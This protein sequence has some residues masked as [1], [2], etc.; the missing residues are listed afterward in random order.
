MSAR[1]HLLAALLALCSA[2]PVS[3]APSPYDPAR[4]AF[5]GAV[6]S[7]A[8]AASAALVGADR[9]VTPVA[10]GNP[11]AAPEAQVIVLSPLLQRISRQD[12]SAANRDFSQTT[13]FLDAASGQWA[14]RS[15]DWSLRLEASQPVLRRE[16]STFSVGL[17]DGGP[18]PAQVQVDA[19]SRELRAGLIVGRTIGDWRLGL[20]GEWT[21]RDDR[22]ATTE[23]SGSPDAGQRTLTFD[24]A[25][26][27]GALGAMWS[28][29]PAARWGTEV[30]ATLRHVGAIDAPFESESD[31]LSGRTT[32]AGEATRDA[33]WE[34]GLGMRL[35][36][37]ERGG[38]AWASLEARG[39]ERWSGLDLE[40]RA[41]SSWRVGYSYRDARTPWTLRLGFGQDVQP[42]APEPRATAVG[43]GL[44]WQD[45]DFGVDLGATHRSVR[46]GDAPTEGDIRLVASVTIGL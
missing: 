1:R 28:R 20:A 41:A 16:T 12:L 24:G 5:P 3:A 36:V 33:T 4:F 27:G 23:V 18:P 37:D 14:V 45:G 38:H 26:V 15:R 19:E 6:P 46:R 40:T 30:G 2:R 17:G 43:L 31:L 42:G 35:T 21:R 39:A 32:A 44:G 10:G 13:A 29:T 7:P 34:A 8:T 9:W 22:L 25:S 11:A